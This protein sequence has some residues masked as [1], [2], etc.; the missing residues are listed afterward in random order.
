MDNT[1]DKIIHILTPVIG[2]GLAASAVNMQCKKMGITS[3]ALSD[4]NLFEFA[5]LFK[6]PLAIFAGEKIAS[7]IINQIIN[8]QQ[9][10]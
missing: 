1:A 4:C 2:S 10:P 8:L 9:Y 7:D 3:E 6:K 5:Q